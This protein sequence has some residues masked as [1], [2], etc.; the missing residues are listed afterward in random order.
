[1]RECVKNTPEEM[2]DASVLVGCTL[3]V[4]ENG[5]CPFDKNMTTNLMLNS[6][7]NIDFCWYMY[8]TFSIDRFCVIMNLV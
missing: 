2:A 5:R 3:V 8:S 7:R 4:S 1:V 6:S